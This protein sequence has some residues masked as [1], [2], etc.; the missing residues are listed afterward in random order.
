MSKTLLSNG[1][2]V[3]GRGNPWFKADVAIEGD[4]ITNVGCCQEK[5]TDQKINVNGMVVYPGSRARAIMISFI[6][7]MCIK[8]WRLLKLVIQ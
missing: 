6:K 3:Y 5:T 2:V 4:V 1:C 7:N 8:G